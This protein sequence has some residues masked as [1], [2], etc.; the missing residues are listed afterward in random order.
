MFT[1]LLI[2]LLI[3]FSSVFFVI[4]VSIYALTIINK[5][6]GPRKQYIKFFIKENIFIIIDIY[7][8]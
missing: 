3:T 8:E 6:I 4:V 5:D 7:Y 2:F 1:I